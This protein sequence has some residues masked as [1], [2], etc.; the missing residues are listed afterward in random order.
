M[1]S[2]KWDINDPEWHDKWWDNLV[3]KTIEDV[4]AYLGKHAAFAAYLKERDEAG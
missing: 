3:A 1:L 4:E 2:Q